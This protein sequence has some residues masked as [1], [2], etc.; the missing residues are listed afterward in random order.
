MKKK[1]TIRTIILYIAI[2]LVIIP[3]FYY[4]AENNTFH[5]LGSHSYTLEEVSVFL[6]EEYSRSVKLE[7]YVI[8]E[9]KFK[10]KEEDS[11]PV[12]YYFFL[13]DY[14]I[15][16]KDSIMNIVKQ[17][18]SKMDSESE[19][20][21]YF[22]KIRFRALS[23]GKIIYR[24]SYTVVNST[25][26]RLI[27]ISLV[28]MVLFVLRMYYG[29]NSAIKSRQRKRFLGS[30]DIEKYSKTE[31]E[32]YLQTYPKDDRAY[33]L[34]SRIF[35]SK[36]QIEDALDAIIE[37][38]RLNPSERDYIF[39]YGHILILIEDY[40]KALGVHNSLVKIK[41]FFT[42]YQLLYTIAFLY[43]KMGKHRT[44]RRYFKHAYRVCKKRR[45]KN[46]E[47]AQSIKKYIE[48]KLYNQ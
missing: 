4:A 16:Q 20:K 31:L 11:K 42:D 28:L 10:V 38:N 27:Y 33:M 26:K 13:T 21:E 48:T 7:D 18:H 43:E 32:F 19:I 39:Y 1:F 6:S 17:L 5:S 37:A 3:L 29:I 45:F 14:S 34:L 2:I 41:T 23:D 36:G 30:E 9:A 12:L 24:K 8:D 35:V 15:D 40:K 22:Y 47:K 25:M 46:D 44:A